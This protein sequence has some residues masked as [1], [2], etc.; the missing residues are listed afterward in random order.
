M[1]PTRETRRQEIIS[2][3]MEHSR[4]VRQLPGI[5]PTVRLEVLATQF[6]ASERRED[7]YKRIQSRTVSASRAD[8]NDIAFDAER[9][10]AYHMHVGNHEEAAWLIFLMTHF[11]KPVEG[12]W[13]RLC[14]VYG[15]L[16]A[17]KWD[18][19]TVSADP[20]AFMEWVESNWHSIRGKFG[21]HRK[22]ESMSPNAS[23]SFRRVL[24]DYL[25]W[26][27]PRGHVHYFA[28]ATRAA[29]NNP[30]TIFNFLF[31]N[32]QVV[33]FGRLA[34]FDYLALIG[35]FGLIPMFP[36]SAYLNGATGPARGARLLFDGNPESQTR[37]TNLQEYID[38][39][40]QDIR[41]G[42]QVMEDALCNWQ[43][44]PEIFV[45]F[46]G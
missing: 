28:D 18:W 43:K 31:E 30:E 39:L 45:H 4:S 11:A 29:G 19:N 21:N 13:L 41:V 42:M 8:P 25:R 3:L 15:Q 16:G 34:K 37:T 7:Y 33:S 9:A 6:I 27:G 23:R 22:Y 46:K 17:G 10:V 20:E 44:S 14:D 2:R 40:D 1:W 26:I 35:R 24:K 36:G 5:T 38:A 32:M 12:G